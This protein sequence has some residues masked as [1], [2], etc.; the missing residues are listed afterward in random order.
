MA[1]IVADPALVLNFMML[2][3]MDGM[4]RCWKSVSPPSKISCSARERTTESII[5]HV[6]LSLQSTIVIV[7]GRC[8]VPSGHKLFPVNLVRGPTVEGVKISF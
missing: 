5:A 8:I 6:T 2:W 3:I 4:A 7:R 1:M